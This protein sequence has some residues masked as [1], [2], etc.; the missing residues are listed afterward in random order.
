MILYMI[1]CRVFVKDELW[2]W[3]FIVNLW[4]IIIEFSLN[5]VLLRFYGFL[6]VID[7]NF[8]DIDSWE[9]S[10]D[11]LIE[12]VDGLCDFSNILV[13]SQIVIGRGG[14]CF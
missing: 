11:I 12:L 13:F 3:I 4:G 5:C 6:G 10:V 7:R 1:L 14:V 8:I 9:Y 2:N